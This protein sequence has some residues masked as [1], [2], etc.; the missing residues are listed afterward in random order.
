MDN[1]DE[2]RT[3]YQVA[4]MGTVSGAA[5]VLGVH[6]ATVIR[7]IDSIEAR[8]GV[9]L[10]QR[11]ARGYTPTEAGEDLLRVAQATEDQFNQLVGRM[12][13]RGDD[14]AGELVV[15][16]LSSLAP[17]VVPVLSEFQKLHPSVIVRYLT[18]DRLFRLE[19]GEAHVAIRAGAAPDQPDN[20]VQPFWTQQMG[21]YASEDY[22]ARHGIPSGIEDFANHHFVGNDD[23][24]NRAPFS[25]WLR[26]NVPEEAITFRCSN[27]FTMRQAVLAGAGIGFMERWE[28]ARNP[29]LQE[30]IDSMP[31][32]SGKL[33]LVTHVDL[34]RTT[35][36]QAFLTFL[37]TRV[38][39]WVV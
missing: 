10:F 28:A 13:G 30:V 5:E 7:H 18:G 15:T 20:V 4:R 36:V 22:V 11:H 1:W 2:V 38:K 8:L 23:E 34:H 25:L 29:D 14:V 39:E 37:K 17:L 26:E 9:K 6:H 33:W 19:Y 12:K 24:N 31:E 32:W 35:K 21:L 16:S 3:A 27:N